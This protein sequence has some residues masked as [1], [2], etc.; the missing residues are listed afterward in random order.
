MDRGFLAGMKQFCLS[1]R[2]CA[3]VYGFINRIRYE[4]IESEPLNA[5]ARNKGKQLRSTMYLRNICNAKPNGLIYYYR[6]ILTLYALVLLR[7]QIDF[8]LMASWLRL[9]WSS[10]QGFELPHRRVRIFN[11][12]LSN[13]LQTWKII[14]TPSVFRIKLLVSFRFTFQIMQPFVLILNQFFL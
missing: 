10:V 5:I 8:K 9:F 4:D 3:Q 13:S 1:V 11:K 6:R 7:I 12:R 2:D 14:R